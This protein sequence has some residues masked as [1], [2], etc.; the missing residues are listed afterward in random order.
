MRK[1]LSR[2]QFSFEVAIEILPPGFGASSQH[3]RYNIPALAKEHPVFAMD[4]V[5]FGFSEK[6][7]VDYTGGEIWIKQACDFIETVIGE[8]VYIA[9]NSLG[10]YVSLATAAERP[11]L[12]KGVV[13]LN[14]A[15]RFEEELDGEAASRPTEGLAE[16]EKP[17][18]Q[19]YLVTPITDFFKRIVIS[20]SFIYTKQPLRIEQVTCPLFRALGSSIEYARVTLCP[21]ASCL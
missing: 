16:E 6:A 17:F 11:D 5:G 10:G 8:P 19:R 3:W 18:I 20:F 1:H 4:M 9:G 7:I 13:L 12:V 14:A 21:Y 2:I 15:G